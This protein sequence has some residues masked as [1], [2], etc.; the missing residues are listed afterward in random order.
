MFL[1]GDTMYRT[2]TAFIHTA[3]LYFRSHKGFKNK[4]FTDNSNQIS[5]LVRYRTTIH[6][7][8]VFG[9]LGCSPIYGSDFIVVFFIVCGCSHCM[10]VC[11]FFVWSF[12]CGVIHNVISKF[13]IILLKKRDMVAL[14][15]CIIA[16]L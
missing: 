8:S 4:C 6:L 12:F 3:N 9:V 16:V 13:G 2:S 10:C 7:L 15:H 1:S 11:V 5:V 14:L